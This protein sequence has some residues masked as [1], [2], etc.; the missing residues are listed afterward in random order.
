ML[1]KTRKESRELR[2]FRALQARGELTPEERQHYYNLTKGYQG[3]LAF[4]RYLESL[5]DDWLIVNDL[6]LRYNNAS[7]QIDSLLISHQL[8]YLFETKNF[9]GDFYFDRDHWYTLAK[10]EIANPLIQLEKNLSL[11]RRLLQDW[12]F[13]H[14]V[15]AHLVFVHPEFFLYNA[16]LDK[17]IIFPNQIKRFLEKVNRQYP[18]TQSRDRRLAEL[19]IAEHVTDQPFSNVPQYT[20]ESLRKGMLCGCCHSLTLEVQ[21][22]V[23]MCPKCG[24]TEKVNSGILRAVEEYRLL[25]P[26]RKITTKDIFDWCK[27]IGCKKRIQRVLVENFE[28]KGGTKSRYY[29]PR[30]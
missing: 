16:P 30:K 2:L 3:E 4:D 27:I 29:E 19:L 17:P 6:F 21:D 11:L 28:L 15:C 23:L 12:G 7:F 25:F 22:R 10:K 1:L 26:E 20:Y 24:F 13:N 14:Q 8:I 18:R 9:E 5:S